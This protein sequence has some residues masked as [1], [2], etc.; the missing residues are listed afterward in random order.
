[1]AE[2]KEH[3]PGR[4][5]K[6]Y[7]NEREKKF[8]EIYVKTTN[9]SQSAIEAGYAP[10]CSRQTANKLLHR[11]K[12]LDYIDSLMNEIKSENILEANKIQEFWTKVI[13]DS[14]E[15]MDNRLRASELLAKAKM[16]FIQKMEI[17]QT[18]TIEILEPEI[19]EEIDID[20]I[21]GEIAE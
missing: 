2:C 5:K 7:L 16:L 20:Q 17:D 18:T 13:N 21:R 12:I 1:M 14:Y 9:A 3:I 15:K 4:D 11:K 8:A 6:G 19:P 10:K